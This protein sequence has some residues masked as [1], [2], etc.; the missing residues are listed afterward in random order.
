[1]YQIR[2][3]TRHIFIQTKDKIEKYWKEIKTSVGIR[4]NVFFCMIKNKVLFNDV[5][6]FRDL[7]K[8]CIG[9]N[10]GK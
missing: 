9:I 2:F 8:L 5:F 3:L 1:M 10:I 7:R 6:P 4:R